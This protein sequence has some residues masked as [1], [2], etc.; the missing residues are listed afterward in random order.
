LKVFGKSD[1][2]VKHLPERNEVKIAY[3]DHTHLNNYFKNDS[4]TNIEIGLTKMAEWVKLN[5]VK[6]SKDFG[7]LDIEKNLPPSWKNE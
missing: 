4:H 7:S 5:G 1:H 2:D 6:T 3:S